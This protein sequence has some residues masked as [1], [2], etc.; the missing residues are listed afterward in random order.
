MFLNLKKLVPPF[1]T[2]VIGSNSSYDFPLNTTAAQAARRQ[3]GVVS[4][5]HPISAGIDDVFD[6][7]LGGKEIPVVRRAGRAGRDRHPA[8]R[9]RP[10][11]RCGIGLLN[12]GF[13]IAPGAGTDVFTNWRGIRLMPGGA[14]QYVETGP[15]MNWD[16]WID[17]F[18]EGRNFVT[19]G[20]LLTFTVNGEPM[21]AVIRIPAG[22]PYQARL[23]AEISSQVPMRLRGVHPKRR[24]HRKPR[25]PGGRAIVPDGKGSIGRQELLVCRPRD[26]HAFSRR[27]R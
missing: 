9:A 13:R 23:A 18:R 20:P 7:N 25:S 27:V 12:C 4:Y 15:G 17:R 5:A 26:R 16:K 14:R 11:T 19:N 24:R 10:P 22:Q 3:G 2:S 1:F 6:T 21:G 8:V